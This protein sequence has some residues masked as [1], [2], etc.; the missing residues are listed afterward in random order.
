MWFCFDSTGHLCDWFINGE[1]AA[2]YCR[3]HHG[4]WF[5]RYDTLNDDEK[6]QVDDMIER[7]KASRR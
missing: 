1:D 6:R 7:C 2:S 3:D 4:C 5:S